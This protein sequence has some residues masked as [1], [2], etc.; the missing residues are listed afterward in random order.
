MY[1]HPFKNNIY[2][3]LDDDSED[4]IIN[5]PINYPI[6]DPINGPINDP[7]ND[8]IN[9]SINN[10]INLYNI[11]NIY[12]KNDDLSNISND[13]ES[14]KKYMEPSILENINLEK[15]FSKDNIERAKINNK[16]LKITDKG[17]YSISKYYDAEW[18]TNIITTFLKNINVNPL[19]CN[20]IDGTSGIGGNTIDFSKYF[21]KVY[22]IE[23][24]NVHYDVLKNNLD[25][26]SIS[27]VN[28]H[29]NNFLNIITDM[30]KFNISSDIFFFDPP[31]GGKS[32]KNFKFFN[33]KIGKFQIYN[34]INLL[35]DKKF[36]YVILKAPFNLNLSPIYN[37]M[38]YCNM[39]VYSNPKKNMIICIFY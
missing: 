33:L 26:L 37:N 17:L 35:F 13:D 29:L 27:N 20:I 23:I 12:I 4:E 6:N 22:A 11:N 28:P 32:Y 3:N 25:A 10:S 19:K 34:I 14:S 18:I 38:K 39:N 7:I 5:Y 21:R 2:L 8:S 16:K 30:P 9:D 36:K 1:K 15:Y 24:N 31:W